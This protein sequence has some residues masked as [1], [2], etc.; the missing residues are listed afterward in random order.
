[1]SDLR[2]LPISRAESLRVLAAAIKAK[3][4]KQYMD[5][6]KMRALECLDVYEFVN[7]IKGVHNFVA[8]MMKRA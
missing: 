2:F 8:Y 7:K 6:L 1:M 3:F 4:D 5:V